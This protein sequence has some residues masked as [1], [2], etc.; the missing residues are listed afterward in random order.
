M[1]Y[2]KLKLEVIPECNDE[3][4]NPTCWSMEA[5][6]SKGIKQYV[7]ISKYDDREFIVEDSN[8]YNLADHGK[9]YKTLNGAKRKAEEI[10]WRQNETGSFTN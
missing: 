9:V 4:D 7:Y 8:G 5:G 3:N 1:A 10:C 2:P 6:E